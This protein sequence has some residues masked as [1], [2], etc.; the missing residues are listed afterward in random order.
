MPQ[1][2]RRTGPPRLAVGC[3]AYSYRDHLR[4]A[5][6]P[7]LTMLDFLD[8]CA[9]SGCDGVELTSYYL[10]DPLPY[11]VARD[12]AGR[13][14]RLGL[15]IAGTAVGGSLALAPGEDRDR[16]IGLVRRWV[17][18]CVDL[19]GGSVRVFAGPAP[20][21]VEEA[22]AR[23]WAAEALADC[24]AYAADRGIFLALENHG[25]LTATP[26]GLLDL[27]ERVPS[28]WLGVELDTG[29][30][31][32]SDPYADLSACAPYAIS[33]HVKTEIAPGGV[34]ETADFVRIAE[35]LRTAGYRGYLHLEYE[36]REPA[37][38][39]VPA[40]LAAIRRAASLP[41]S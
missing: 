40:A 31:A 5:A 10:P 19:G 20:T 9:R 17:D 26:E 22:T 21:G 27:L 30:F 7:A 34:P 23:R 15:H 2:I 37:W 6:T 12:C 3:C 38:T 8:E 25:G 1:P 36:G 29:N 14:C 39:S 18:A 35:T 24:A 16:Q 33:V 32:T 4:G 41:H 11:R 28:E 13:A